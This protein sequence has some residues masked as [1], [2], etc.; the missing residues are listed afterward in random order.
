VRVAVQKLPGVESVNV[1]LERASTD[2]QLRPGNTITLGQLRAII[3]NNGFTTKEA[4]VTAIGSLVER[5]GQ[6]ALEVTGTNTVMLVV[7]D[8]K[9]P[10]VFKQVHDRL[11]AKPGAAARL[12]GVVESRSNSPDQIRVQAVSDP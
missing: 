12:V 8:P 1:S 6:P 7:A 10:A 2:I 5:G 4:V 3:K 11:R 9:Q